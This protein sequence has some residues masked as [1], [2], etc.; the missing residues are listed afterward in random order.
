MASS[1]QSEQAPVGYL[2]LLRGNP[3]FRLLWFSQIVSLLGDWF[4][5][6][7]ST[8]L[9]TRFTDSG[10]AIGGLLVVR[11]LAPF[12]VSPLAGIAADRFNRKSLLII[13]DV[14]RG[15]V[16]LGFLVVQRPE[17]AW[18]LYVI[19]GLQTAI[20]G[21]W[22]PVR[23][24]ILP[25][26]VAR[27]EIGTANAVS[28]ATWSTMLSL[29]AA[30]GG[31]ATGWLGPYPSFILDSLTFFLSAAITARMAY[32]HMPPLHGSNTSIAAAFSQYAEGIRYL[33]QNLDILYITLHKTA[34]G[35]FIF[36]PFQVIQVV[37]AERVFVIGENGGTSLGL[38]YAIVGVGTGIGPIIARKF[39]GDRSRPL[40]IAIAISYAI[41]ALGLAIAAPLINFP[42]TLFGSLLRGVGAGI[43]WVFSSQLLFTLLPDR[44]RGR[45]FASEFAY[46]TLANAIGTAITGAMLDVPGFTV[47]SLLGYIALLSLVPG[48]L[49]ML[50]IFG[51]GKSAHLVTAESAD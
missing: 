51:A 38:L 36:G 9:L 19:T 25:D 33:R 6:I 31:I 5:L 41:S 49:W 17:Q 45:V 10:A 43:A 20:T 35:L 22:F 11:M 3:N 16:V 44:V 24:A 39:T 12:I 1:S 40:R 34:I 21:F 8:A 18:L 4:D 13:C 47:T 27:R 50:W 46:Q 37:I 26:V 23:S 32:T 42:I 30:L 14:A 28:V 7:A 2:E 15:F 29:G 48:L